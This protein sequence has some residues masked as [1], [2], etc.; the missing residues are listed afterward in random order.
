MVAQRKIIFIIG[1]TASGKSSAAIDL[2]KAADG[3]IINADSW[4]V[5]KGFDV[6]T[7]KPSKAERQSIP[8]HLIDV[9][10]PS[11]GYSAAEFQRQAKV[12]IEDIFDRRKLPIVVGGTGLYIDSLLYDYS[13][14]PPSEPSLRHEYNEMSL[15]ELVEI[16]KERGYDLSAIDANNKRR[17]IRLIE[18]QGKF[19]SSKPVN[20]NYLVYGLSLSEDQLEKN[21]ESRV[22]KMFELGLV[23][24][25]LGLAEKYGWN[26]E[27]M[28]GIGYREFKNYSF[29][30]ENLDEVKQKIVNDT[31]K[32]VK[33]QRTWFKRNK[34]IHWIDNRDNIVEVVTTELNK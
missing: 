28:K 19:P 4:S 11:V 15:G 33:K 17:V 26:V 18:N 29:G 12:V 7:A 6:G 23:D 8:H 14:L 32:L 24:E 2:A 13:F 5:Y 9:A 25:V 27:P 3:E 1:E 22:D 34:L 16:A 21:I 30:Q 31:R 20:G 10:D